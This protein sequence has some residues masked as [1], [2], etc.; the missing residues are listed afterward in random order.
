[1]FTGGVALVTGLAGAC[2]SGDDD[3]G[4]GESAVPDEVHTRLTTAAEAVE[5]ADGIQTGL[6][7]LISGNDAPDITT[8]VDMHIEPAATSEAGERAYFNFGTP[9]EDYGINGCLVGTTFTVDGPTV[10]VPTDERVPG[11]QNTLSRVGEAS[12]ELIGE[13]TGMDTGTA[14]ELVALV[15]GAT[16]VDE[17]DDDTAVFELDPDRVAEL[18][19]PD[20]AVGDDGAGGAEMAEIEAVTLTARYH[21]GDEADRLA[22]LEY[23]VRSGSESAVL[24]Y[25]Y[26]DYGQAQD[27]EIPVAPFVSPD[28]TP[29]ASLDE[30][31]AF[32]G[33]PR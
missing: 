14:A 27:V 5:A 7:I 23:E 9:H 28:V 29:L 21:P 11:R 15:E 30:L 1:L 10:Y 25:T 26:D 2:S 31:A 32:V 18:V 20:L 24:T 3:G 17:V 33:L 16:G 6:R 4:G 8:C 13:L 12:P 19:P 22:S